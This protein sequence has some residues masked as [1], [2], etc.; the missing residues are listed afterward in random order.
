MNVSGEDSKFGFN[1]SDQKHWNELLPII[2][3]INQLQGL[4]IQGLMT[5]PPLYNDPENTRLYFKRLAEL[6]TYFQEQFPENNWK[7]LSMGTSAD[8]EV[9]VQEGATMIRVGQ[10]ISGPRPS[11]N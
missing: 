8:Y 10:A 7:H 4:E 11:R 2:R 9:A 6:L 3:E 1:A 5:M